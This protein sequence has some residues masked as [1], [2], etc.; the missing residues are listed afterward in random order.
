ME[1]RPNLSLVVPIY[2]EAENLP[3][4]YERLREG[5][6]PMGD[7]YEMLFVDDGSKD[8]G[9]AILRSLAA[10]DP[11]V[12]VLFFKT[13]FG[14]TAALSAGIDHARGRVIVTLDADLQNDPLDIPMLVRTLDEGHDVVSGWRRDRQDS[15]VSRTLPSNIANWLISR[16]T[17]LPLHDY[18]CTLKAY[19]REVF[20]EV[21]LYGEM[22]RFIPAYAFWAGARVTEVVVRH[23]PRV[24]GS[25]KYG[26]S[27]TVKVVLDLLT[28]TFLHSYSTKPLYVFGGFGGLFLGLAGLSAAFVAIRRLLLHGDWMSPLILITA[29]LVIAG[30]QFILM[31]LLAEIL[32]RTYHESQGKPT[33]ALRE[34]L[35]AAEPN[36]P[37]ASRV[38]ESCPGEAA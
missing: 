5:V 18:G 15:A 35:G 12:R 37:S 30:I 31:G 9:P 10:S 2:N 38:A 20:E 1:P 36:G 3:R 25:S 27:R 11:H 29:V 7:S 14:Q 24:A 26:L 13:N 17:G 33:Y 19:R 21:R 22:H 6:A 28:M 4:L 34:I 8:D 16:V 32:V 23:H